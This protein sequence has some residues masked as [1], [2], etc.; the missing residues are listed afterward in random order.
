[1]Q[2][3]LTWASNDVRAIITG[4]PVTRPN[5]RHRRRSSSLACIV[6]QYVSRPNYGLVISILGHRVQRATFNSV[7]YYWR[8]QGGQT[9]S[10][11]SRI[12]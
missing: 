6:C 4:L 3:P 10:G 5:G 12:L 2:R 9:T 7:D 8:S 1:M 11:P